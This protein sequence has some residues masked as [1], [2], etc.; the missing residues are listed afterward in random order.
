MRK[1]TND[2]SKGLVAIQFFPL[3]LSSPSSSTLAQEEI[4]LVKREKVE[5]G[6]GRGLKSGIVC[7]SHVDVNFS[8]GGETVIGIL[9]IEVSCLSVVAFSLYTNGKFSLYN[10]TKYN[11]RKR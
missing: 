3:R 11:P 1:R 6:S 8:G 5:E 7:C 9:R 2:F 10:R 4:K